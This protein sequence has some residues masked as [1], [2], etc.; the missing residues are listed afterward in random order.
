MI[1]LYKCEYCDTH[2]R[3]GDDFRCKACGAPLAVESMRMVDR[4]DGMRHWDAPLTTAAVTSEFIS[5]IR[6]WRWGSPPYP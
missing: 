3:A 1:R 2:Q 6:N 4:V 5:G